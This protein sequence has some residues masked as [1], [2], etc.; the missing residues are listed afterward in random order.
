MWEIRLRVQG[1]LSDAQVQRLAA[2]IKHRHEDDVLG[3]VAE[4]LS[5]RRQPTPSETF[6][7][8]FV[9]Y[10][11]PVERAAIFEAAAREGHTPRTLYRAR[12]RLGIVQ[13]KGTEDPKAR[14]WAWPWWAEVL[15][16][17]QRV[18]DQ[19]TGEGPLRPSPRS[20]RS[21]RGAT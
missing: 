12:G 15:E 2:E 9:P 5:R 11:M 10:N 18:F 6:L 20:S 14:W 1:D 21:R 7:N 13:V 8:R 17:E 4:R 19:L 3:Y 16:H